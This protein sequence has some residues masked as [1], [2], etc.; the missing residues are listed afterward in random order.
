MRLS[1]ID[2]RRRQNVSRASVIHS[3]NGLC[4]TFLLLAHFDTIFDQQERVVQYTQLE[5]IRL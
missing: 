2:I 5:S 1:V 4:A 3:P